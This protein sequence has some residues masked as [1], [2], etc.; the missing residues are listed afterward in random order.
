MAAVARMVLIFAG[1]WTALSFVLAVAVGRVLARLQPASAR[2]E[3]RGYRV[4]DLRRPR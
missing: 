4:V 1:I 2:L 3:T